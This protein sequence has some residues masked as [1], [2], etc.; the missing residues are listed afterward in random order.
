MFIFLWLSSPNCNNKTQNLRHHIQNIDQKGCKFESQIYL[1][2]SSNSTLI[3]RLWFYDNKYKR[4]NQQ[5]YRNIDCNGYSG[6][7]MDNL[8]KIADKASS[9]TAGFH[10]SNKQQ[11]IVQS[12]FI[13]SFFFI[14]EHNEKENGP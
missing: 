13:L 11:K 7:G 14:W 4:K 8:P 2:N 9:N 6:C 3:W 12:T 10:S 5:F 1:T